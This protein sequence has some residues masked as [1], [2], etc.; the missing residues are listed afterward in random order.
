MLTDNP[1]SSIGLRA[2][3]K[4]RGIHINLAKMLRDETNA[5]IHVYCSQPQDVKAYEEYNQDGLFASITQADVMATSA[6]NAD[7]HPDQVLTRAQEWERRLDQSLSRFIMTDRHLGRSYSL[8]G[9]NHPRSPF[10]ENT[11]FIQA[12]EGVC[13]SLD[14]WQRE[15][16]KRNLSLLL[17]VSK[18]TGS[19]AAYNGVPTRSLT[20][21]KIDNYHFWATDEFS[22]NPAFEKRFNEISTADRVEL[23]A[24]YHKAN[25]QRSTFF[26]KSGYMSM[27]RAIIR[28]VAKHYYRRMLGGRSYYL[29]EELKYEYRMALAMRQIKR[30]GHTPLS[31]LRGKPFVYFPLQEEPETALT[32]Q[33]PEHMYQLGA[34][35][36]LARDL[37]AGVRLAVKETPYAFGRRTDN[38]YDQICEFKNVVWL[39]VVE[40][41]LDVIR[42]ATA[43]ATIS[44]TGGFEGALMGKPIISFGRHNFW[45]FIPHVSVVRDEADIANQLSRALS[46]PHARKEDIANGARAMQAIIDCSFDLPELYDSGGLE[47]TESASNNTQAIRNLYTALIQSFDS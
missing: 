7:G 10:S 33:S 40:T 21:S 38:F 18:V 11:N 44:G 12:L 27:A 16:E 42:E 5:T 14:F 28:R 45:N 22:A 36:S 9:F 31:S 1:L 24:P 8:G 17:N 41:G 26:K 39:D 13:T 23:T 43:V 6:L 15:I 46:S 32:V 2:D 20:T 3:K 29:S 34:I 30:R 19:I 25:L 47:S 4:I 37:P 35:A